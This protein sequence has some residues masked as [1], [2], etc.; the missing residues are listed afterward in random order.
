MAK[1]WKGRQVASEVCVSVMTMKSCLCISPRM[2]RCLSTESG[3]PLAFHVPP[4]SGP[5][6]GEAAEMSQF[7]QDVGS[8]GED[9]NGGVAE[10]EGGALSGM[11]WLSQSVRGAATRRC[12]ALGA[13]G[14]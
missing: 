10:V 14:W 3:R 11:S 2:N 9:G 12:L 7:C 1:R 6:Q 4:L 8:S 13:S 5:S